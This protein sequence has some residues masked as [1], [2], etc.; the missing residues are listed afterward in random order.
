MAASGRHIIRF[1]TYE[2]ERGGSV[3]T[4]NVAGTD[5]AHA[6]TRAIVCSVLVVTA[7]KGRTMLQGFALW[8]LG[9]P[10]VVILLLWIFGIL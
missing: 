7:R 2:D 10:V 9:V 4:I 8:L 3:S 6:M 5:I 1:R